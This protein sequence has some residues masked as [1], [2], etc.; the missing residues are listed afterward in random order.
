MSRLTYLA[1][2][3]Y[4][5]AFKKK[6]S[7][8]FWYEMPE[9]NDSA[10]GDGVGPY[11][12]AFRGKSEYAGPFDS[13]GIPLLDYGGDIGRQYNPI[14]IAQYGLASCNRYIETGNASRREAFLHVADWLI[15]NL[16]ENEAGIRVWNHHFNWPYRQPLIAPWYSGLAQGAG[17]SVLVR[18]AQEIGQAQYSKAAEDAFISLTR[19]VADG[20]VLVRDGAGDLWIE[21]YLVEPPSHILNGFIWAL[22][23]VYD[24][25]RWS[26]SVQVQR[27]FKECAETI[28]RNLPRYDAGFWSLY[29]LPTD[30]PPMLASAYYHH[31]H[32]TQLRVMQRMTG[33][34]IFGGWADRWDRYR[35]SRLNRARA[36]VRK[37]WFKVT[38]Y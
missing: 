10:F 32:V 12:M 14:A 37:A 27:L 21:E 38:Q 35:Q 34:P 9:V 36:F 13:A 16:E 23:G 30:G 33:D 17:V 6:S 18:A 7:L 11:Y 15:A 28:A 25:S 3:L 8:A 31:L 24:F 29:E 26:G 5:Y 22:W 2:I 20:G 4:V 1:R 19:L